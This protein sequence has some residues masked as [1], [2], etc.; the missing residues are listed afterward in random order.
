MFLRSIPKRRAS[1]RAI[2]TARPRSSP[3]PLPLPLP[4]PAPLPR[5]RETVAD[6][7]NSSSLVAGMLPTTV[8]ES[9]SISGAPVATMSPT[10]PCS[11]TTVPV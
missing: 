6:S 2:G 8:P 1:A 11:A 4:L 5:V 3:L 7:T 9:K 10:A